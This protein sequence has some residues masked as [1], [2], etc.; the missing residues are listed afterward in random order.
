V[1]GLAWEAY[2]F[3]LKPATQ[4]TAESETA[5]N[6]DTSKNIDTTLNKDSSTI[7]ASDLNTDTAHKAYNSNDTVLVHYIFETTNLLLRA[8]SRTDKLKSY[9]NNAGYDSVPQGA[10]KLYSLYIIKRTK[11]SDTL[12]IK[13]SLAKFLQKEIQIKIP[14]DQ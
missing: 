2:Q 6:T 8:Q 13:D 3:F 7:S 14:A 11:I 1:G 5:A 4:S 10:G 9:G 12:A